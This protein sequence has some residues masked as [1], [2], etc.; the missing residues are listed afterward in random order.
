MPPLSG[1]MGPKDC[2]STPCCNLARHGPQIM[3]S[4]RRNHSHESH[5]AAFK[6]LN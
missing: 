2:Y 1:D 6:T 3:H 5:R 4:L